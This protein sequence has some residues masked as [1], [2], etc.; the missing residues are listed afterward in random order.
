M[1]SIRSAKAA[2]LEKIRALNIRCLPENYPKP[3]WREAF[4]G[5]HPHLVATAGQSSKIVGYIVTMIHESKL[6]VYSFAVA[7]SHRRR[8]IGRQ[9]IEKCLELLQE[10]LYLQV[11]TDNEAALKLYRNVGFTVTKT[12]PRFYRDGGDAFEM[13]F[14]PK[15]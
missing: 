5:G 2:D 7:Q 11:R 4:N 14:L 15:A 13:L 6:I 9:L 10:P 12:L 8:G 1:I 3:F